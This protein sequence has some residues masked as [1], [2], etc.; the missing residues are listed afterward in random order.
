MSYCYSNNEYATWTYC[1]DDAGD[2]T[3]MSLVFEAGEIEGFFDQL[4]IHDGLDESAPLIMDLSGSWDAFTVTATNEFGCL[5]VV[6][7]SDG[8]IS[9]SDFGNFAPIEWCSSCGGSACAYNWSW[10][11]ADW[12][13]ASDVASPQ[14][15]GLSETTTFIA[16]VDPVGLDY[17]SVTDT[18]TVQIPEY[19]WEC[20]GGSPCLDGTTWDDGVGQCVHTDPCPWDLTGDGQ[21]TTTDLL[22]FLG[23]F[24]TYCEPDET[25]AP[26]E[27]S[28]CGPGTVWSVE[29]GGCVPD[30]ACPADFTGD[31][32]VGLADLL[33]L[34]PQMGNYCE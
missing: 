11:P 14:L 34:L 8:I 30:E 23:S 6:L 1:P 22:S 32:I 16:T 9:C 3:M 28:Y 17:C 19:E 21:V 20:D 24:A 26:E 25:E 27:T 15:E 2:G 10:E 29:D 5:Y 31:G 12:L 7:I 33:L 18:V 4:Y 13:N